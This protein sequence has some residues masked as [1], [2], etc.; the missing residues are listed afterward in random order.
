MSRYQ[1]SYA[2]FDILQDKFL[3]QLS[4]PLNLE[5]QLQFWKVSAKEGQ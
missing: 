4:S 3:T 5:R 1:T 2:I